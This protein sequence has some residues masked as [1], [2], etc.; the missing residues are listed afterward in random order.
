MNVQPG[1]RTGA[2]VGMTE[3]GIFREPFFR[4]IIAGAQPIRNGMGGGTGE[5]A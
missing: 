4:F 2:E 1:T 5:M 3:S